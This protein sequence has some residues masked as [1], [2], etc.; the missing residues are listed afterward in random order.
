MSAFFRF[1]CVADVAKLYVAEM[2][3]M[4]QQVYY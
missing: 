4:M 2:L 1:F 3:Q